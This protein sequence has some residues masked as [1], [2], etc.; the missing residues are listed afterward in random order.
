[1]RARRLLPAALATALTAAALLAVPAAATAAG[2]ASAGSATIVRDGVPLPVAPVGPCSLTGHQHGTSNGATEAGL[3]TYGPATSHCT[4]DTTAHTSTSTAKGTGFVLTALQDYGG[5]LIRVADYQVT[6]TATTGGT[7]ASWS[8]GGLTGI[9]VPQQI[10]RDYTV[11]VT[12]N[13]TV[14]AD[15]ILNEVILPSPN[16]GSITLNLI[17]IVLFPQGTPP[18]ATPLR[19]DI[20]VGATACSPTV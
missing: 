1:M 17:H 8:F 2:V 10:P 19:G 18:N 7:N 12:S 6:C 9:A 11:P 4:L 16:D 13:G 14:L 3:V 20:Y 15:V 5:P